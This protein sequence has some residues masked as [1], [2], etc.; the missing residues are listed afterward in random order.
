MSAVGE[1]M[2]ATYRQDSTRN[3]ENQ[4]AQYRNWPKFFFHADPP[5]RQFALSDLF[6][7]RLGAFREHQGVQLM[8]KSLLFA[9]G[10]S[11]FYSQT[12]VHR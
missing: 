2:L 10:V 11:S 1:W 7:A 12:T 6:L 4:F 5:E 8:Q 3:F 9:H